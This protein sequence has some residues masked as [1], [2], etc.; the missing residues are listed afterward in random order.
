[1][2]VRP[3]FSSKTSET[4]K[5][6]IVAGVYGGIKPFGLEA[7]F[8]SEEFDF[9][10]VIESEP[11]NTGKV[12]NRRTIEATRIIDPVQMKIIQKWIDGRIKEYERLS[13]HI[14]SPEELDNK[15]RRDPDQ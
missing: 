7:T 5:R 2:S 14:P 10:K 1:M 13:G 15:N 9:E 4:H 12:I 3:E 11:Q 6:F 8:Y